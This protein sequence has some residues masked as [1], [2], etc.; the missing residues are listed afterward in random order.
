[1]PRTALGRKCKK[2]GVLLTT[3]NHYLTSTNIVC[4]S[5][6]KAKNQTPQARKTQKAWRAKTR[7]K[8]LPYLRAYSKSPAGKSARAKYKK[9]EKGRAS[10]ERWNSSKKAQEAFKRYQKRYRERQP[11]KVAARRMV[12]LAVFLG[13]LH[14]PA[15]CQ[16][17]GSSDPEAH[18]P[19]YSRPLDVLWLCRM[20]HLHEGHGGCFRNP[21]R[22]PSQLQEDW[23]HYASAHQHT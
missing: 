22:V 14:Q 10:I 15:V 7:S 16:L 3:E 6:T 2:C 19:D 8:R 18:H 17:C 12:K 1:M 11:G 9:S 5:C 21:P 20:C 4:K 23:D 13:H